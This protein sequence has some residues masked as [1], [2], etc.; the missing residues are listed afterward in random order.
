MQW[1]LRRCLRLLQDRVYCER[2]YLCTVLLTV[3]SF[4]LADLWTGALR[5]AVTR[6]PPSEGLTGWSSSSSPPAG[7]S[8]HIQD[9]EASPPADWDVLKYNKPNPADEMQSVIS[10]W[11]SRWRTRDDIS[12]IWTVLFWPDDQ[13]EATSFFLSKEESNV[14]DVS[15]AL[16]VL[17]V[18]AHV[19][20]VG[21][22]LNLLNFK[23][24]ERV[25]HELC[26]VS[27]PANKQ[28]KCFLAAEIRSLTSEFREA[29]ASLLG[30]SACA[31]R[32]LS[33]SSIWGHAR[34]GSLVTKGTCEK[35]TNADCRSWW[36]KTFV[37]ALVS[38]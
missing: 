30:A 33:S 10:S 35:R 25:S 17:S 24:W 9:Q 26:F 7:F 13:T 12:E 27:S 22:L 6:P 19:W 21:K 28:L 4:T 11:N 8:S 23:K 20:P 3:G 14:Q 31:W 1:S 32:P 34:V 15:L 5:V 38:F 29:A 18:P 37:A 16:N 36:T 2:S